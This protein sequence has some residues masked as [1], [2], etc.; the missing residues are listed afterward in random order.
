GGGGAAAAPPSVASKLNARVASA[1]KGSI[2]SVSD[3]PRTR[4]ITLSIV[5]RSLSKPPWV[6]DRVADRPL[7]GLVFD[8]TIS[9]AVRALPPRPKMGARSGSARIDSS[10]P[11]IG[12]PR[13]ASS[14]L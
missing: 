12:S 1:G 3:A 5:E 8:Q 9:F 11:R 7:E 10:S 13:R 4:R 2:Q 6:V 14:A